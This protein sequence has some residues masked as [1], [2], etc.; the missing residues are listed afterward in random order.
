MQIPGRD[1]QILMTEQKLDGAQVGTGFQQ[2]RGP[3]VANQVRALL[4]LRMPASL[5]AFVQRQPHRL[6]ADRLL[7]IA[8]H[9]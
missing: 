1:L 7:A 8:M 5:A 3:A 6:V 4:G 9:A 2:M